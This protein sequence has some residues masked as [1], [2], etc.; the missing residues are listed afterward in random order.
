M[1]VSIYLDDCSYHKLLVRFLRQR[2]YTVR[3]PIEAEISGAPDA[4]HL[5]Y[6]A[7]NGYALLTKN[8][9]DF[10]ELHQIWQAQ[11]RGHGGIW[12]TYE[13]RDRTKNMSLTDI[14]RAIENLLASGL[15]IANEL[16]VLNHW[17]WNRG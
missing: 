8:T 15:P 5:K 16:H 14:V 2:G 7:I 17:R 10:S 1:N 11:G 4:V 13:E 6:A 9:D 12:L 3:T